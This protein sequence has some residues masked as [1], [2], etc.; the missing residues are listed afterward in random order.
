M[1]TAAVSPRKQGYCLN[2]HCGTLHTTGQETIRHARPGCLLPQCQ[3]WDKPDSNS[4]YEVGIIGMVKSTWR[5]VVVS[6]PPGTWNLLE[7][8]INH[9]INTPCAM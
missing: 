2:D 8:I 5:C 4:L 6:L 9:P 1:E 3:Q 7:P